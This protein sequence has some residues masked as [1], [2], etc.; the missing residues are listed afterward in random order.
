M[1][2]GDYSWGL[3]RGYYRD[4]FA[5]SLRMSHSQGATKSDQ[6][7]MHPKERTQDLC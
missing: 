3:C 7:W 1:D 6:L 5:L 4:P 2:Y